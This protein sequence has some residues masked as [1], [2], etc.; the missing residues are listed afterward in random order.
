MAK[1]GKEYEHIV[2]E[3]S[4]ALEPG[5][6]VQ[7]GTWIVG[8]DGRRD[9]DVA[10]RGMKN[11]A[12]YFALI[13]CKDWKV[14]VGIAVIDAL[15]SKRTDLAANMAS[16]YSNSGFTADARSKAARVGI[17]LY[18][19]LKAGSRKIRLV[20]EREYY[21]RRYS[22]DSWSLITIFRKDTPP[23]EEFNPRDLTYGGNPVVNWFADESLRLLKEYPDVPVIQAEY[24]FRE[25]LTF[26]A[27][28]QSIQLRGLMFR[29]RCS[30]SWVKQSV[31]E[32][33]SLGHYDILR[34]RLVI[35]DQQLFS[36]GIFANDAWEA[37][38]PPT[39]D[40]PMEDNSI[41]I[42]LSLFHSVER[43][44]GTATPP[45]DSLVGEHVVTFPQD[46]D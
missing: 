42:G 33:V 35:P 3:V 34:S 12:P 17:S 1:R 19:A 8:P 41:E 10:I 6:D 31:R 26:Q 45:L 43:V 30:T 11:E 27:N 36:I 4:R 2:G 20:I 9:M 39:T 25:E 38:G 32:D 23:F 29:L 14:P 44:T 22:V 5:A 7:V 37:T 16:V 24:A 13:E 28:Q 21:A 15:D 46:A 40:M 18:S